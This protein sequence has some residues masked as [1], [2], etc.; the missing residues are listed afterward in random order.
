MDPQTLLLREARLRDL[1]QLTATLE[2]KTNATAA[3]AATLSQANQQARTLLT[4]ARRE[5]A[6]LEA[7]G[8]GALD[9]YGAFSGTDLYLRK[10]R[11]EAKAAGFNHLKAHGD[12]PQADVA[13]A[14]EARALEIALAASLANPLLDHPQLLGWY[15]TASHQQGLIP[16]AT[17]EAFKAWALGAS[18]EEVLGRG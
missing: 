1:R 17:W 6:A 9:R 16:E 10:E 18:E 2:G 4:D 14:M 8:E 13:A 15:V 11:W 12:A 7:Q 3:L 5:L